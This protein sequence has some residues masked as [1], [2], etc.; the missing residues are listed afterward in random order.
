MLS[1]ENEQGN[2]L[3][4]DKREYAS[5]HAQDTDVSRVDKEMCGAHAIRLTHVICLWSFS[6]APGGLASRDVLQRKDWMNGFI[7]PYN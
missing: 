7:K 3:P 1:C 5:D 2:D 6:K 4:V